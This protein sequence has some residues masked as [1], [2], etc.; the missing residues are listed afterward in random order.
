MKAGILFVVVW[1]VFQFGI[2]P[3]VSAAAPETPPAVADMVSLPEGKALHATWQN[4]AY[5]FTPEVKKALDINADLH[6]GLNPGPL[7]NLFSIVDARGDTVLSS[8]PFAPTT[9]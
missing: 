2:A 9:T 3:I 5:R 7:Y 6:N 1:S 8:R 4:A